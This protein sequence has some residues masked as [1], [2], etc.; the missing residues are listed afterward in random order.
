MSSGPRVKTAEEIEQMRPAGRITAG[1]LELAEKMV[2]P[3][4]TTLE[5]DE[6]VEAYILEHGG[7]PA[8]KGYPSPSVGVQPFPGSICASVNEEVVHG[9]PSE[10]VRLREGD[11]ISIDVGVEKDGYFGDAARTF[12][13]GE[14]GRKAR[15]LLEA[16]R[17]ALAAA[18]KRMTVGGTLSSVSKAIETMAEERKCSVVRKFVG[19]G[20]GRA[21]HE[22]PQVPNFVSRGFPERRIVLEPGLVLAIEP[23][24]NA[25]TG[26][27]EVLEDGWTTV[28]R[29]RRLS[30]HFED[31][32]AVREDGPAVLTALER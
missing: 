20:I 22:P 25:G 7:R 9:I 8:F 16:G 29:D 10:Q 28:T 3:G 30:V 4:I 26:D 17:D 32:V 12:P 14:I 6:A 27:V 13:V 18:V 31:T 24:V 11:I 23:M 2:A 21:M 19:H 15:R 5:I 1:A